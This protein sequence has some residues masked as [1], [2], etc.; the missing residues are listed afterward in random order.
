MLV[1]I[2]YDIEDDTK[3]TR[4]HKRLKDFGPRVQYSVFEAEIGKEELEKLL[5][6]LSAVELDADDSIRLYHICGN[7]K[8]KVSIWGKGEITEDKDYYIV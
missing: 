8:N 5:Q 4:L 7:C 2:S 6:V 1:I 3:R